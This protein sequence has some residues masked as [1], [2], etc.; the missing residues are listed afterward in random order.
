MEAGG[1][2]HGFLR[3]AAKPMPKLQSPIVRPFVV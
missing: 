2:L 1:V 3:A